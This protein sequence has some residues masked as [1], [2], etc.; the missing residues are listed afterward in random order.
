MKF[1]TKVHF[2]TFFKSSLRYKIMP[3]T[4]EQL[5]DGRGEIPKYHRYLFNVKRDLKT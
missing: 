4:P 3:Q 5:K 1:I 2:L